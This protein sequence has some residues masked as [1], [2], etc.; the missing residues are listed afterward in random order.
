[1]KRKLSV[2]VSIIFLLVAVVFSLQ[3]S[4]YAMSKNAE[5]QVEYLRHHL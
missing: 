4:C 1:M 2:F 3:Q 5:V